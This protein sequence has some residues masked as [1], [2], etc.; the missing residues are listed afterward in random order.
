MVMREEFRIAAEVETRLWN[1]Y[2]LNPFTLLNS[3]LCRYT[4]NTYEQWSWRSELENSV[5][6]GTLRYTALHCS[7][8]ISASRRTKSCPA[9]SSSS[10]NRRMKTEPGHEK[11]GGQC[12]INSLQFAVVNSG[13]RRGVS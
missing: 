5:E 12:R 11:P 13:A 9:D 8:L 2:C 6:V 3:S 7:Q 4:S 1:K 10:S